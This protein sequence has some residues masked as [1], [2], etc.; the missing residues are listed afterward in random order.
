[1]GVPANREEAGFG[2]VY[3]DDDETTVRGGEAATKPSLLC[4]MGW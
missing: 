4:W 1:M 2:E 3:L